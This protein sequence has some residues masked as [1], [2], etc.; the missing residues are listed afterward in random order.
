[1]ELS[2]KALTGITRVDLVQDVTID[3]QPARVVIRPRVKLGDWILYG[4]GIR[5]N[6]IKQMK[7][8]APGVLFK[9]KFI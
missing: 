3:F 5:K 8:K 6:I 7:R 4:R 1:M 2:G 9:I